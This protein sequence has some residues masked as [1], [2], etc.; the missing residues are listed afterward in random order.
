MIWSEPWITGDAPVPPAP[1]PLP[2]GVA[3]QC[4]SITDPA[5]EAMLIR[6]KLLVG[7]HWSPAALR[8]RLGGGAWIAL[9][10][11]GAQNP[12]ATCVFRP[13]GGVWLL[14]TLV[15]RE[16]GRGW[17]RLL[18]R[19]AVPWAWDPHQGGCR[20]LVYIWELSPLA[21]IGAWWRGWLRTVVAYEWGWSLRAEGACGF[22]PVEQRGAHSEGAPMPMCYRDPSNG[23][24]AVISDTGLRDGWAYVLATRGAIDWQRLLQKGGWQGLWYRGPSAPMTG[25]WK[26]TGETV[27]IGVIGAPVPADILQS[28]RLSPEIA[29]GGGD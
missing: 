16:R 5:M 15:A 29:Y 4:L 11:D 12:I 18:L 20:S 26:W 23:S 21:V 2:P 8:E 27:V 17:G 19:H 3:F 28:L 10:T 13:R 9:L 22:C 6:W 24:V 14:E 7:T 25:D 1:P